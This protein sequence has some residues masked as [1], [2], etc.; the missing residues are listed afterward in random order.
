MKQFLV[1]LDV[2]SSTLTLEELTAAIGASPGSASHSVGSARPGGRTRRYSVWRLPSE[3]GEGASLAEHCQW[4]RGRAG[5]LGLL[6]RP[7]LPEGA[8]GLLKIAVM[9][10]A[11]TSTV[12]VL[13]EDALPFLSVGFALEITFYP[14]T[15]EDRA[16]DGDPMGSI[17]SSHA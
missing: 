3:A 10:D 8:D 11:V 14:T 12:E 2:V 7:S 16:T 9:N 1:S 6:D 17:S 13:P 5:G 15:A 4:L